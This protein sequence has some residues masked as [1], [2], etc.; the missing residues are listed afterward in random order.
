MLIILIDLFC[1]LLSFQIL[2]SDKF[3]VPRNL[4]TTEQY[5]I[6][7]QNMFHGHT[8]LY[9]IINQ[10]RDMYNLICASASTF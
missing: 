3:P 2:G 5:L 1:Y 7:I 8:C 6:Y 10:H 9:F 4:G